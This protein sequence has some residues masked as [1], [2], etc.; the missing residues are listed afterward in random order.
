MANQQHVEI[1]LRGVA[2]W[3]RWR[4][5]NAQERPDLAEA[6][7]SRVDLRGA[8]LSYANIRAA[9][10]READLTWANLGGANLHQAD[11]GRPAA[12]AST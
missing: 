3:N 2:T 5:E 8:A 10:L 9:R 7:L 1:L 12:A 4:L 11:Y 6:D